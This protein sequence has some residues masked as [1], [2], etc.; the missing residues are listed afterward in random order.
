M[1]RSLS[2]AVSIGALLIALTVFGLFFI[3]RPSVLRVAVAKGGESQKLLL[4]V[5]QEFTRDHT[6]LRLR[7]TPVA[8]MRA[9][10]KAIEDGAVDLAVIRSDLAPPSNAA[11]ALI[12]ERQILVVMA[13]AGSSVAN[14]A[15]L[16]GKRVVSVAVDP[17]DDDAGALFDAVEQQFALPPQTLPRKPIETGELADRLAKGEI[18]AVLAL[19]RFDSPHML[20]VVRAVARGG[21]PAFLAIGDAAA[22][23]KKD[24]GLEATSLLRGAFGGG[25][26]LPPENV[27]TIGVTLRLVASNDL[28]NGVVGELVRQTLAHRAAVAAKARVANAIETPETDKDEALPTHPGAAAFIDDE[29]ESFLDRYSDAIYL[30]AMVVS[31]LASLGA[32]L[33]SRTTV[34]GYE[35][36]DHLLEQA[37]GILKTAREAQDMDALRQ[38][39][40]QIDEILT[41]TLASGQIPKLDGHQLA[42]LTLA[43]EQARLAIKDRRRAV[44]DAAGRS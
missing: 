16:N 41:N 43:V 42:G 23:A 3:E 40:L 29:E 9:A 13:P 33:I 11:T 27:E 35:Q 30:G 12:L 38:L 25:P 22:M 36:F 21:A 31:L 4:A 32:T 2:L 14:I 10:A 17:G 15:D 7:M 26:S 37:L 19:G 20:Q 5:N 39:E 18:D 28:A 24:R 6:D 44:A 8:D 34:R 1:R